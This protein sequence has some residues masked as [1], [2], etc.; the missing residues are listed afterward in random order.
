MVTLASDVGIICP[1]EMLVIVL[2]Y[3]YLCVFS[4]FFSGWWLTYPSEKYEPVGNI[5]PYIYM[6]K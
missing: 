6:G 1:K 5:I 2:Y 4:I 3:D